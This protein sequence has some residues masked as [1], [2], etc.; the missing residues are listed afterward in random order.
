MPK[1]RIIFRLRKQEIGAVDTLKRAGRLWYRLAY[2]RSPV[3]TGDL[4]RSLYFRVEVLS[5]SVKL[6]VGA[7]VSYASYQE[8]LKSFIK[9][10]LDEAIAA[11]QPEIRR[12]RALVRRRGRTATERQVRRRLV[13]RQRTAAALPVQ[14]QRSN[15]DLRKMIAEARGTGLTISFRQLRTFR[16]ILQGE[17]G[18]L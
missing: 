1:V 2:S 14:F 16:R 18:I 13:R 12:Q 3:L 4:R 5:N 6:E 7:T 8:A 15:R 9:R 17:H 11:V 10:S